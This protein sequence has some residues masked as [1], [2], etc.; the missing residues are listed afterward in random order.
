MV[1]TKNQ[2]KTMRKISADYIYAMD[3]PRIKDGVVIVNNDGKIV[4]VTERYDHDLAD[5]EIYRGVIIPGMINT[6]CHMELSHM[7]GKIPTG[8]GLIPF[9]SQVVKFRDFPQDEIDEAIAVADRYMQAQG[10]VA[11]GDISNKADTAK[12]KS[13]STIRYYTFVEMFD[14]IQDSMTEP[15][16]NQYSEVYAQHSAENGNSK[17]YVPHAP[18]TVSAGLYKYIKENNT[19]SSTVSIH[20]QETKHEDDLFNTKTG[21][22]LEFYEGFGFPLTDFNA[23]GKNSIYHAMSQM[24]PS[25]R[26]LFVHNTRTTAEDI[27]AAQKWSNQV[28][29]ATCAN[30]N[31]Y[32]ENALPNYQVFI[33]AQANMTIGTD[34]LS[35][36]WQL[37]VFEEMKTIKK[38]NSYIPTSTLLEWA[39]YNGAMALGFDDTLGSFTIG[40]TPG[41][42]L[43]DCEMDANEEAIL[44]NADLKRLV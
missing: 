17:S 6:H 12:V 15:M 4:D 33:D 31:L 8:T 28:Y 27:A 30:A 14:F 5:L 38:Y 25:Q 22:F 10:I 42:V 21:D 26:T 32:I 39:T 41:I 23:T 11:V 16:I 9:I 34:S 20:N 43:I 18:Y 24:D 36:N 44:S 7:I 19:P 1:L 35:S 13:K 3:R 40:K 2:N 29:W 37:S